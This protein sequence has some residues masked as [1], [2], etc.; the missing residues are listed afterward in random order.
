MK[1]FARCRFQ[2]TPLIRG[3]TKAALADINRQLISIHSSHVR[4]DAAAGEGKQQA[5][6]KNCVSTFARNY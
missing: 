1:L 2:S 3:E 5:E 4:G 6:L